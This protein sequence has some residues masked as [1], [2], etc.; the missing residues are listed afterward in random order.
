MNKTI[1]RAC[2]ASALLVVLAGA[3][4]AAEIGEAV[5]NFEFTDI[6]TLPRTISELG[7]H[8]ATVIMF[9]ANTCPLVQRYMPEIIAI[10]DEYREKG[11]AFLTINAAPGEGIIQTAEFALS[12]EVPFHVGKDFTGEAVAALGV[13]RT[14]E[15][16]V[17]DGERVLRYRGR[18]NDQYRLGGARPEASREDL[19]E[20]LNDILAGEPV[21]V[22]TTPVDGCVITPARIEKPET[23]ITYAEH[24]APILTEHCVDCHRPG[25]AA[26]FSLTDFREASRRADVLAEVVLHER[27]PPW[28]VSA[29]YGPFINERNMSQEEREILIQWADMG[30]LSGDLDA[31]PEPAAFED[32]AWQ[33]GEPDLYIEFPETY[34]V[35]ASGFVNYQYHLLPYQ[36]EEDTWVRGIEIKPTNPRV[37]HHANLV[38]LKDGEFSVNNNFLTGLVPGGLQAN[39]EDGAAQLIPKGSVLALQMH[40]VTTGKPEECRV[41]VGINFAQGTV[42]QQLH[43]EKLSVYGFQ[44]PPHD[45]AYRMSRDGVL[46]TDAELRALFSHMHVRGKDTTFLAHLPSGETETLLVIPNYNFDWQLTYLMAAGTKTLPAGTRLEAIS[47]FD[48]SAFNPY[49][50]DPTRTVPRG[51]QTFDEMKDCF[52]F[53][54]VP[55]ENLGLQIDPSTGYAMNK[56][57]EDA[58]AEHTQQA[59]R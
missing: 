9:T 39:L 58:P 7:E 34:H 25:T 1:V 33:I 14:P 28:F 22:E 57:G 55:G 53:Y 3:P 18:I 12:Y 11:V 8:E 38:Y 29:E 27:M 52:I 41:G 13:T 4:G 6:R 59:A 37:V 46:K 2:I 26:P 31:M 47:H 56:P 17:L 42:K 30:A 51:D 20:A 16:V 36:F 54:T 15:V 21:R 32:P 50:P 23:P 48:N 44:I 35:P 40:Y 45:P 19:R 49:N 24:V 5:K 43:Y 10:H